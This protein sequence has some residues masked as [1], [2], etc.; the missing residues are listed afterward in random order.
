[1][2]PIRILLLEDDRELRDVLSQVLDLEGYEV[3]SAGDGAEAVQKALQF[4]FELLIFDVKLP[5]PD[6]LEI[7]AQFRKDNPDLPSIVITGY[8]TE[9]DTLRALRLGVGEYL[10]KPFN[11]SIFLDAV[12]RLER[13]VQKQRKLKTGKRMTLHLALW[14]LEFLVS[15]LALCHASPQMSPAEAATMASQAASS[16]GHSEEASQELRAAVLVR[17]LQTAGENNERLSSLV[18]YLPDSILVLAEEMT[19]PESEGLAAIGGLC[20][21]LPHRDSALEE[22]QELVG[23]SVGAGS[24]KRLE[25]QRRHLLSLGRSLLASGDQESA[26]LAFQELSGNGQSRETAGAHLELSRLAWNQGDRPN[27]LKELDVV[28]SIIPGLGPQAATELQLEAAH[29]SL[30]MELDQG[31]SLL[32]SALPKLERLGLSNLQNQVALAL[33]SLNG[34]TLDPQLVDSTLSHYDLDFLVR[35]LKWNLSHFLR[36]FRDEP[37]ADFERLLKRLMRAAPATVRGLLELTN[38]EEQILTMLLLL[39]GLDCGHHR[40]KLH[41]LSQVSNKELARQASR[42]LSQDS[43]PEPELRIYSLGPQEVWLGDIHLAAK[44]WR[45]SRSRFLLACLAQSRRV[46]VAQDVLIEQFWPGCN[47][48]RGRKNLSQSL[49]DLRK[50]L[51]DSGCTRADELIVRKLERL[52]LSPD[53]PIWHDLDV[54]T[55]SVRKGRSSEERDE[56]RQAASHYREAVLQVRGNY[57]EDCTMDW[58]QVRRLDFERSLVETLERLARCSSQ[59]ELHPEVIEVGQRILSIDSCHQLAHRL[60]MQAY[61]GQKRPELAV[62]Q[63]EKAKAHLAYE[64][65]LEPQTDLLREL[66]LAKM[67]L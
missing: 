16:A 4:P 38:S 8:A 51:T 59:L 17:Y 19:R 6:G 26:R 5:G 35:G 10:R 40:D 56:I 43:G 65:G 7:L 45:T 37:S 14:S 53:F 9:A 48:D 54:Y 42:L 47:Q 46:P 3:V 66:Q 32:K 36:S 2:T 62:R 21:E 60:V 44:K 28:T 67:S 1:V 41:Q 12:K 52:S 34:T 13:Q 58:A 23:S 11:T 64:L 39:D 61:R 33:Q 57:L 27:A 55:D 63:F 29:I 31:Q 50:V 22:L 49:T 24:E 25:E 30:E 18:T 15:S 20:L